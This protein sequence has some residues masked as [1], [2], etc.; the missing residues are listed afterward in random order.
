MGSLVLKELSQTASVSNLE[1]YQ[2]YWVM[3]SVQEKR[4]SVKS[5]TVY[6]LHLMSEQMRFI[7][8]TFRLSDWRNG[9][10]R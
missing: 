2:Y 6:T 3:L 7:D 9:D 8:L 10:S 1:S 4:S 5:L